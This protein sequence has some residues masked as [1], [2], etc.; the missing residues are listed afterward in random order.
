MSSQKIF[1][2]TQNRVGKGPKH[3]TNGKSKKK[4]NNKK[5]AYDL[6]D[7]ARKQVFLLYGNKLLD[8]LC[9]KIES[10]SNE[11]EFAYVRKETLDADAQRE[12]ALLRR[13]IR[14]FVGN[15]QLFT[16]CL[17]DTPTQVVSGVG[18]T[19][20]TTKDITLGSLQDSAALASIF[21]E[22][23]FLKGWQHYEPYAKFTYDSSVTGAVPTV[24]A[25]KIDYDSNAALASYTACWGDTSIVDGSNISRTIDFEPR[26]QPDLKWE[27]TAITTTVFATNKFFADRCSISATYGRLFGEYLVQFRSVL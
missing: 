1:K 15:T 26:G 13:E 7:P 24:L 25:S 20:V 19:I 17:Y 4:K 14:T 6:C 18:G 8:L 3:C 27:S 23:R 11:G 22:F 16:F 2:S 21:D 10:K 12:V 9:H 5:P